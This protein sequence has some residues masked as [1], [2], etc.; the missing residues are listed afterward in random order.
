MFP[1]EDDPDPESSIGPPA[2][3]AGVEVVKTA[4]GGDWIFT[5][6]VAG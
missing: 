3:T 4:T 6:T 2:E 5:V 1:D